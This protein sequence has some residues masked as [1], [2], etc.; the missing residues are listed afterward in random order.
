M[1][2]RRSVLVLVL[3]GEAALAGCTDPGCIRNS[4]CGPRYQCIEAA[5]V[6]RPLDGGAAGGSPDDDGGRE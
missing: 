5:C 2:G 1:I 4:E 3:A 6:L